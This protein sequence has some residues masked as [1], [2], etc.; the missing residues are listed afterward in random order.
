MGLLWDLVGKV[1]AR[2]WGWEWRVAFVAAHLAFVPV[3]PAPRIRGMSLNSPRTSDK[4]RPEAALLRLARERGVE[5]V[6]KLFGDHRIT[7]TPD[8]REALQF[9]CGAAR[10]SEC[11]VESFILL[12]AVSTTVSLL[13]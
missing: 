3:L 8:M 13:S 12:F 11:Y 4:Q 2:S 1:V 6:A 9:V 5:G 7:S 10:F